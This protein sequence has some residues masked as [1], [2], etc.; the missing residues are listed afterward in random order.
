MKF[1][2]RPYQTIGRQHLIDLPRSALWA[3]MGTGKTSSTLS[4]LDLLWLAGSRYWPA[5]IIAPLRVARGTWPNEV[6]KWEDFHHL[7]VVSLTG[8]LKERTEALRKKADIYTINFE[9]IVWLVDR[10]NDVRDW[11]FKIVIVDESTKLKGF[12]LRGGTLRSKALARV[13]K[14]TPRFHELTGTPAPNGV[15]DLWGQLYFLD[16]GARLGKTWTAFKDRWFDSDLYTH[17]M[18]PKQGAME[19]IA[20]RVKDICLTIKAEDW[21][22]LKQPLYTRVEAPLP[23][24]AEALYKELEK[25]MYAELGKGKVVDIVNAANLSAKC[26]QLAAGAVLA[27]EGDERTSV[28]HEVHEAKLDA[29]E[30][31]VSET[32]GAPLLVGYWW[33]HDLPR[34]KKRFPYARQINT[35]KDEDDW[36]AGKIPMALAHYA[37]LG[38]GLNLQH[39]GHHFVHYSRW[40]DAELDAQLKERIG[41]TRQMQSGYDRV[42][43]EYEIIAPGTVDEDVSYRHR[44]K[45]EIS[46]ALAAQ[47]NRTRNLK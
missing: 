44:A 47:T 15:A 4:A 6:K 40:W 16:E 17:T 28:V 27:K 19:E 22:D 23:A 31:I 26:L 42:V 9:N 45:K 12:R 29:L 8:S 36:N 10:F 7:N 2:P 1:T 38:H 5:L 32:S 20:D 24:K 39:G 34:L 18:K 14:L 30:S 43:H 35:Q 33:A 46:E 3:D 41:P 13:A 25:E 21:F 37:S 11:P